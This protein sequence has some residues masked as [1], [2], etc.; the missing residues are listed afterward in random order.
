MSG[1]NKQRYFFDLY[2]TLIM[3]DLVEV[4]QIC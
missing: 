4:P 1:T 2:E 3:K